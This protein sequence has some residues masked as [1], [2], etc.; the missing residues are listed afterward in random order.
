VP[1]YSEPVVL[2]EVEG[3]GG[4][5]TDNFD[6]PACQKAVFYWSVSPNSYGSASLIVHLHKT[7]SEQEVTLV[8][9]FAMDVSELSGSALQPLSGGEYYFSTENTDQ[10]WTIRVECQD[11][12]APVGTGIDLEASGNIVTENYELPACQKS[13]FAWSVEPGDTG[14]ASL[15][16]RLC[17]N[18]CTTLV[19]EFQMDLTAPME[20]EA[21]QALDGGIYYLVSENT[22]GRP[23]S[24]HWECRD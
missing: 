5:V 3:A 4:T 22:S 1:T 20:G 11:G 18:E 2:T 16:L 24:V 12:V 23:W 17:G 8:N 13:I 19:N 21:L 7:S 6:W 10:P 14:T 9:E 15:I